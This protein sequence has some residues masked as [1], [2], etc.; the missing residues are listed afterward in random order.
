MSPHDDHAS[1][2]LSPARMQALLDASWDILSLLDGEGRLLY[3]SPAAQRLHGFPPEFFADRN[4]FDLIHPDDAPRVSDAFTRCLANPVEPV[5]VRYRYARADGGWMWMEAVAINRLDDPSVQA[6]VVNSRDIGDRVAAEEARLALERQLH[7]AQKMESLG[8]VAG[9]V[10]HDMNN[11]LGS[12]L[13]LS[14]AHEAT[15]PPGA[16]AR[17]AFATITR[18]YQRGRTTLRRLLDFA[19]KDLAAV[20]PIDLNAVAREAALLL[21]RAALARVRFSL[22]LARDLPHVSGDDGALV[23][24]LLNLCTNAIDAM[25][26]GG[27]LTIRTRA[28]EP[29]QVTL[30]VED[31]GVGMSKEILEKA[32]DPFFTTK[33]HGGGTGLGLSIVYSTVKAHQGAL[34]LWSEPGRGT[35]VSIRLPARAT[36]DAPP[37]DAPSAPAPAH[38]A[39]SVLLVDDDPLIRNA[40]GPVIACLGHTF[41]AVESGEAALRAL[42]RGPCPDVIILDLNMP[43]MGG[44]GALP[45]IRARFPTVPVLIATGRADQAALDLA[46]AHPDVT[47]LP[48]PFGAEELK[49]H[50]DALLA[51]RAK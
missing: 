46:R 42:D 10:A 21:E 30:S 8:I 20:K 51:R 11:V 24:A 16:P 39:L 50:L 14:S 38:R 48:K 15:L 5:Q 29:D 4:T 2:P 26:E 37:P 1:A 40:M 13:L 18:A 35:R 31:T 33:G 17:E 47:L 12:I 49:A 36:H 27:D 45:K 23:H 44:R 25:P 34:S 41:A 7:H 3:N 19:R 28:D 22:D 6:V 9:G 32:L 43:G